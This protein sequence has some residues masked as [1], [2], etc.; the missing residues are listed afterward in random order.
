MYHFHLVA[1]VTFPLGL[2][3]L[4][5]SLAQGEEP[6]DS[7]ISQLVF[8]LGSDCFRTRENAQAELLKIGPKA[9]PAL[10]QAA[11]SSDPEVRSR[12]RQL[13]EAWRK[14][15]LYTI[16]QDGRLFRLWVGKE[17]FESEELVKLGQPFQQPEVCVEGLSM[18]P[19]GMLY[20]SVVFRFPLSEESVL[21][22]IDPRNGAA[23]RIGQIL[24]AE[25]TGLDFGLE[26]RLYGVLSSCRHSS[27]TADTQ[28]IEIDRRTGQA[29]STKPEIV[30]R[31]LGALA[32]DKNGRASISNT[33]S[34]LYQVGVKPRSDS[35]PFLSDE[36]FCTQMGNA[37]LEGLC[38][39]Q[40]GVL[41]AISHSGRKSASSLVRLDPKTGK[42]QHIA[43]LSF[44]TKNLAATRGDI[45]P[46]PYPAIAEKTRP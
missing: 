43:I 15:V 5:S 37:Q 11:M 12:A 22:Q 36:E 41:F 32:I 7:T 46:P 4:Y 14:E 35:V 25:L 29:F 45:S 6:L 10:Q 28:L 17:T 1:L 21:Y 26:D 33:S 8:K 34:G 9:L 3:I 16:S 19:E 2:L 18:F 31:R 20:A 39:G 23:K 27:L 42:F 13:V 30:H 24:S 40:G 38:Y 44:P